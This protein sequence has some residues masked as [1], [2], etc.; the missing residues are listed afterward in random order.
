MLCQLVFEISSVSWGT[1]KSI[2]GDRQRKGCGCKRWEGM[3][4]RMCKDSENNDLN[5]NT[6]MSVQGSHIPSQLLR[7]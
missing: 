3:Q 6:P 7:T 4:V 2:L 1:G 5:C